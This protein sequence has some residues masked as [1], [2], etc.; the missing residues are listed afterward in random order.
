MTDQHLDPRAAEVAW[1]REKNPPSG[2]LA[3]IQTLRT[4]IEL[5]SR[6]ADSLSWSVRGRA[7]TSAGAA[8]KVLDRIENAGGKR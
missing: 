4:A 7:K 6:V 8:F 1:D 3:D 5:L 2:E